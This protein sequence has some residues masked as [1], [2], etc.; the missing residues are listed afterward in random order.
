MGRQ[1]TRKALSYFFF[2]KH[3][4]KGRNSGGSSHTSH[5]LPPSQISL[6]H[7]SVQQTSLSTKP[8]IDSL[9]PPHPSTMAD[10]SSECSS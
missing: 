1:K 5:P 8:R 7:S 3:S 9:P 6:P 2:G 4:K 10:V